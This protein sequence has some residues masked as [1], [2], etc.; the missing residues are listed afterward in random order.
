MLKYLLFIFF[1]I[2]AFSNE[3]NFDYKRLTID[4]SGIASNDK[5][6]LFYGNA[7]FITKFVFADNEWENI[8]LNTGIDRISSIRNDDEGFFGV[9]N[10]QN[11]FRLDS[12]GCLVEIQE[13]TGDSLLVLKDIQKFENNYYILSDKKII[14]LNSDL[15]FENE[16]T[17]N[18]NIG[19]TEFIIFNNQ[20]IV[21]TENARLILYNLPSL[22][23]NNILNLY[24]LGLCDPD[25]KISSFKKSSGLFYFID[26]TKIYSTEDFSDFIAH[27]TKNLFYEVCDGNIFTMAI[28]GNRLNRLLFYGYTEQGPYS[29]STGI[30]DRYT[31]MLYTVCFN[32]IDKSQLFVVGNDNF[33]SRSTDGGIHWEVQS[34]YTLG[35]FSFSLNDK[36]A[37]QI[38]KNALFFKT[39][40]GG[41]TWLTQLANSY[42]F[43]NFNGDYAYHFSEDGRGVIF[44]SHTQ[45]SSPQALIT[46]DS[47]NTYKA[48]RIDSIRSYGFIGSSAPLIRN[49]SEY[50]LFYPAMFGTTYKYTLHFTLDLDLNCKRKELLD[51]IQIFQIL[52][53]KQGW[54]ALSQNYKSSSG[55]NNVYQLLWAEKLGIDWEVLATMNV[56]DTILQGMTIIDDNAYLNG[57][58]WDEPEDIN[59]Y[60]ICYI[61]N[62]NSYEYKLIRSDNRGYY[63]SFI[64]LNDNIVTGIK[65]G[66][67][68]NDDINNNPYKWEVDSIPDC[69]ITWLSTLFQNQ[70]FAITAGALKKF[71]FYEDTP[72]EEP[73]AEVIKMYNYP[74][75]PQ[76]A[77]NHVSTEI[78]WDSRYD[79][80]N[81]AITVH[82]YTGKTISKPGEISVNKM[83]VYHGEIIWDC[84][85]VSSG[86]YFINIRLGGTTRTVPVV[87]GR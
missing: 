29:I 27:E 23:D 3:L 61:V 9:F 15:H 40:N 5:A 63:N 26:G 76:P 72:V 70:C 36:F 13:I 52:K 83:N 66:F 46:T 71:T 42:S 12:D 80:Q 81:A 74:P 85:S 60:K 25:V 65:E 30:L 10:K 84:S 86:V 75:Y 17:F 58:V 33:I 39:T 35:N 78:Y 62:L 51:S 41:I 4:Y 18:G 67:L 8:Y 54:I 59:I 24:E 22:N 69:S 49:N 38:E 2:I 87:V 56:K 45:G 43:D 6:A 68:Y 28:G 32:F 20:L 48:V 37:F 53:R 1:P 79:M 82:D 55:E 64:K 21:G 34:Y 57:I 11:V 47:G 31:G 16:I 14:V 7:D 77:N 19:V 44:R 73:G 50:E